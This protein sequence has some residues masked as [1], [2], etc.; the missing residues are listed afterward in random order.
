MKV[1]TGIWKD[2]APL[3]IL[4]LSKEVDNIQHPEEN[5]NHMGGVV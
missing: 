4:K 2:R 3:L 1:N 5:A